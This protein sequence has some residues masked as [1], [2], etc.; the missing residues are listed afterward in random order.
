MSK[1]PPRDSAATFAPQHA[2]QPRLP[3]LVL[4]VTG[5]LLL[6]AAA[7]AWWNPAGRVWGIHHLAFLPLPL[8]AILLVLVI[9][10]LTHYWATS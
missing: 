8:S 1:K 2:V 5:F 9:V 10:L 7:F 3:L 4:R 6:A